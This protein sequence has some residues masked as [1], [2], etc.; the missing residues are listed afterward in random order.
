MEECSFAPKREGAKT[1]EKYLS[2]MGRSTATPE[3]FFHYHQVSNSFF[4]LI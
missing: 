1:S 4:L 2:R 3:D